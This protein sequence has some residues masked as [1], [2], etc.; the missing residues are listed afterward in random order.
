MRLRYSTGL[1]FLVPVAFL[2]AGGIAVGQVVKGRITDSETGESIPFV[3]LAIRTGAEIHGTASGIDGYYTLSFTVSPGPADSL[4][5][6]AVG[7]RPSTITYRD[8]AANPNRTLAKKVESLG[9]FEVVGREDPAYAMIR[10]AVERRGENDPRNIPRFSF[11]AY[12][13]AYADVERT[14]TI[15]ASLGRTG[16][17]NAHLFFTE[18]LTEVMYES[19]GRRSEKVLSTRMSGVNNPAIG[20]VSNSFQPFDG[21]GNQLT[22]AGFPFLNPV[23]PNSDKRYR[24]ELRDSVEVQGF[25][26]YLIAFE[27][28]KKNNDN[29]MEGS[30][31]LSDG[32]WAVVRFHGRN[33]NEL[34][35]VDFEIR[36]L[37]RNIG[38]RW[39][40]DE[41]SSRFAIP[42]DSDRDVPLQLV[43]N[44]YIDSVNFDLPAAKFPLAEIVMDASPEIPGG[45][46]AKTR[47]F[48]LTAEE[49]NTYAVYDTLPTNA[50]N[51]LNWMTR[52][53]APL[54]HNR[55]SFGKID[56]ML[57]HILAYNPHE[58]F[59]LGLGLATNEELIPWLQPEGYFAYG[60]KD[61]KTKYG[62]G[63]RIP[64]LPSRE[65]EVFFGYRNDV[66]EPG[67]SLLRA[68]AGF[69]HAGEVAR[70]LFTRSMQSVEQVNAQ[71]AYRPFRGVRTEVFMTQEKRDIGL[72]SLEDI[73][74]TEG[75]TLL[76]AEV[77]VE[78]SYRPGEPLI[79]V[80]SALVPS[81]LTY[82]RV[83]FRLSHA[84]SALFDSDQDFT[85][86]EIHASHQFP[87]R[88]MGTAR[89]HLMAG[90]IDADAIDASYLFKG[91]GVR[92]KDD[93]GLFSPGYF[94]TMGVDAFLSERY[95]QLGWSQDFGNIFGFKTSWAN[96]KLKL[97]YQAA[98]G[99]G[100]GDLNDFSEG[101]KSM[102][103]PFLEGGVMIDNLLRFS[104]T[105][106]YSGFGI[107]AFYRHGHYA[108]GDWR[109]DLVLVLGFAISI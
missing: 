73:P 69:L 95:I 99:S 14:D 53:A 55:L 42:L 48:E 40:P 28:R 79:Q 109:R 56:V 61:R 51:V 87:I 37:C 108:D 34:A 47:P 60:F 52:Q 102:D 12:N 86:A 66:E 30:L 58:G 59:R 44:T 67:R 72:R 75:S 43:S 17:A 46:W 84:T 26:V 24:F 38:G 71:M 65:W 76:T 74:T 106:Y 31:A 35:L 5:I 80:G 83:D 7:Y 32:E 93:P 16:F 101:L 2:L 97:T 90:A 29:L 45:E 105:F 82:P 91:R 6:S 8:L 33:A 62:G 39:F 22:L 9:V 104:S 50:L 54:A 23:S 68:G 4:R 21:Y 19:P 13:K 81:A 20:L 11:R 107:G 92:G 57:P 49:T 18:S 25:K 85:K 36:R 77:G 89:I 63:L 10:K 88:R 103:R 100:G 27:P 96:P 15:Q 94:Q 3:N 78:I 1:C 70:N 41:M 98:I 64:L